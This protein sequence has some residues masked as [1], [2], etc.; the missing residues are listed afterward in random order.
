MPKKLKSQRRKKGKSLGDSE[1]DDTGFG[2]VDEVEILS[3]DHTVADDASFNSFYDDFG[4]DAG[5]NDTLQICFMETLDCVDV[6]LTILLVGKSMDISSP[7]VILL[8][9]SESREWCCCRGRCTR[10]PIQS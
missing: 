2:D 3:E 7:F 1:H 10:Y 6:L 9:S 5:E 8:C 4:G